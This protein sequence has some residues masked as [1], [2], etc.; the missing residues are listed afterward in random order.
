M[1]IAFLSCPETLPGSPARRPDA[2]EHDLLFDAL[3]AGLDGRAEITAIDWRA[4]LGSL[5]AFDAA[6]LGTPWDYTDAKDAFLDRLDAL[7]SAGVSLANPAGVVRWNADKL[8]LRQLAQQGATSIPTLW[9]DRAG[10][11]DVLAAFDHFATDRVVVKRRVGAGAI[12]QDSFTRAAPPAADWQIDQ[13]AMIQPFLPAIQQEGE[14]SFIFIDGQ[15]SHALVKR[16]SA[17]DYRIQSLYGGSKVPLDPVPAD[18]AAA[19]AIMAM[20]PFDKPPVYARID[21][22][23]LDSGNL[24]VI[25]AELIEPYL[26]PEQGP[27]FGRMLADAI[28]RR[29]D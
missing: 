28:L 26:Y 12:G 13:A 10:P 27:Q 14:L 16:A 24:A 17:G 19:G 20:L 29:L 3:S 25:E 6:Y 22:V 23:R 2:F 18:R 7:E 9:P 8:Y 15:F 1:R 4:P 5:T 11:A 21:M